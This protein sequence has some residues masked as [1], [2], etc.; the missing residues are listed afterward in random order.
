MTPLISGVLSTLFWY[1]TNVYLMTLINSK[2]S[3][4]YVQYAQY[5][6]SYNTFIMFSLGKLTYITFRIITKRME[7][8]QTAF[9]FMMKV[10]LPDEFVSYGIFLLY[11]YFFV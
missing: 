11:T 8:F 7:F 9:P 10:M 2:Y 4:R 5:A 1:G 6:P 3:G